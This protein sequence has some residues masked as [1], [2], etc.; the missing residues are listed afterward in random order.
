M[1]FKLPE[2]WPWTC[3]NKSRNLPNH[4]SA[5]WSTSPCK[6]SIYLGALN[7]Y[8][9]SILSSISMLKLK[10][11]EFGYK[12]ATLKKNYHSLCLVSL[13]YSFLVKNS[14]LGGQL[15]TA[16]Q[17]ALISRQFFK[18]YPSY[19][20]FVKIFR[21]PGLAPKFPAPKT[22]RPIILIFFSFLSFDDLKK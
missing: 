1:V 21:T 12:F 10:Y 19:Q 8:F 15:L 6:K 22:H 9:E 20:L 3:Q 14:K 16:N 11:T 18:S 2:C 4:L 17:I 5:S 13:K 7:S